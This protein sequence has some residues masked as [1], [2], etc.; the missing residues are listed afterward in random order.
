[1][2]PPDPPWRLPLL[3][4]RGRQRRRP[5]PPHALAGPRVG[6]GVRGGTRAE[7]AGAGQA[8]SGEG[9][10]VPAGIKLVENLIY[11]KNCRQN[12]KQKI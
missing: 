10:R 8:V 4:L 7:L 1:M 11:E 3:R 6:Q 5:P 9:G 12:E 2:A